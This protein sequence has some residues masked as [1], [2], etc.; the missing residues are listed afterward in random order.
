MA[1]PSKRIRATWNQTTY[2]KIKVVKNFTDDI[3]KLLRLNNW[4]TLKAIEKELNRLE[5]TGEASTVAS[6]LRTKGH[7]I[8]TRGTKTGSEYHLVLTD[9]QEWNRP[10]E[11][12]D[13]GKI[14]MIGG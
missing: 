2:R 8:I 1:S 13:C 14:T 6:Y 9:K 11:V 3:L 10:V 12:N 5:S 7:N 4:V